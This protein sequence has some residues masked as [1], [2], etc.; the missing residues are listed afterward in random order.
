M[1]KYLRVGKWESRRYARRRLHDSQQCEYLHRRL[2]PVSGYAF[3]SA[4][5]TRGA[6]IRLLLDGAC[7]EA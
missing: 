7:G 2:L 4:P 1:N 5:S 6:E 3:I